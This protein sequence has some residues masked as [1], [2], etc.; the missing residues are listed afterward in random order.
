MKL[1][2]SFFGR[3]FKD[4]LRMIAFISLLLLFSGCLKTYSEDSFDILTKGGNEWNVDK[5]VVTTIGY[6][7]GTVVSREEHQNAGVFTFEGK[8]PE[9]DDCI[10]KFDGS[11]ELSADYNYF[12]GPFEEPYYFSYSDF[13][14]NPDLLGAS[15]IYEII[16]LDR[17]KMTLYVQASLN[18]YYIGPFDYCFAFECSK[19]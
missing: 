19:L 8:N 5:M 7:S 11:I 15:T 10:L 6:S 4:G 1:I 16:Y 9:D 18:A 13:T 12:Y 3:G 2:F 17:K 14:T